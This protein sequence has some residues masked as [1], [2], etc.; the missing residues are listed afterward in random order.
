MGNESMRGFREQSRLEK[1]EKE[2]VVQQDE[3]RQDG[4]GY[5]CVGKVSRSK[6]IVCACSPEVTP[7]INRCSCSL[8]WKEGSRRH[9]YAP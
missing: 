1:L 5:F 6:E 3:D 9:H 4:V 2:T 8:R 7:V